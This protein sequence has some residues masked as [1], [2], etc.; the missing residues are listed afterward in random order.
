VNEGFGGKYHFPLQGQQSA[1]QETSVQQVARQ[2]IPKDCNIRN[3][4]CE[5]LKSYNDLNYHV[6]DEPIT[7]LN[8]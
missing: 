6:T 2:N 5:N 4:C 8:I 3:Y 1:E 7:N